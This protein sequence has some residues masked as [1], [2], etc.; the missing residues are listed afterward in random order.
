VS[1]P[2]GPPHEATDPIDHP[3]KPIPSPPLRATAEEGLE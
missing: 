1:R 3:V 2:R